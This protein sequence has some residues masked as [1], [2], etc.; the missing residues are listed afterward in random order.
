MLAGAA[1]TFATALTV[2]AV[3]YRVLRVPMTLLA[4]TVAGVFTQTALLGYALE[5]T[6]SEAPS[7][8]YAEVYAVSMIGKIVLVQLLLGLG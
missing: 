3:G 2:L 8:S 7:L 1:V 4:G 5:T 6:R